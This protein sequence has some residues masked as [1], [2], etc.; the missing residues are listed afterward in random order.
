[1]L[2]HDSGTQRAA[3]KEALEAS[4]WFE[5]VS[6]L[7]TGDHLV[8]TVEELQ[9]DTVVVRLLLPKTNGLAALPRLRDAAP[10]S[11]IALMSLTESSQL[12]GIA[13]VRGAD[14][15]IEEAETPEFVVERL[16]RT[17]SR[18]E[19]LRTCTPSLVRI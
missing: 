7:A 18:A 2:A 11:V 14:L 5:V 16:L 6:E 13:V 1:V 8:K 17:M 12:E 10:D 15:C 19:W 4:G 9:P 3:L